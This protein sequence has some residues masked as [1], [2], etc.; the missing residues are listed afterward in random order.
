MHHDPSPA[1]I[2]K[3]AGIS[4]SGKLSA[5]DIIET[6]L[7]ASVVRDFAITAGVS[8]VDMSS[9]V[10]AP[11]RSISRR[12]ANGKRLSVSESDRAYRFFGA[13]ALAIFSFGDVKKALAWIHHSIPSLG[14]STPLVLLRTEIGTQ[15]VLS[16]CDRITYGG[17]S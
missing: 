8:L 17:V 11:Q 12:A 2:L 14:G 4:S 10:G 5:A 6:G 13:V 3:G 16:A 7:P 15:Q 9:I 1:E